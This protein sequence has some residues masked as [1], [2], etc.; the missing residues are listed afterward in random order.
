MLKAKV[1]SGARSKKARR[2][3]EK[4]RNP[5]PEGR[6]HAELFDR[7]IHIRE[8]FTINAPREKLYDFWRH[9]EN[10]PLLLSFV[11]S[12]EV[13]DD[14]KSRWVLQPLKGASEPFVW[15]AEVINDEP[16]ELIA[17]RSLA[18]SDVVHAG[19]V[20]FLNAPEDRGTVMTV[21]VEYLPPAG[22]LGQW[23][24]KLLGEDPRSKVRADLRNFKRIIETGE[25]PTTV[26]QPRGNCSNN[27]RGK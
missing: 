7:G 10:L 12:V 13:Y 27:N 8:T 1:S 21:T 3:S 20:R 19:S 26:G 17:W 9:F 4:S 25:S 6:P 16:G 5:R 22:K 11:K 2:V 23:A 24:A 14:R 15:E 18:K